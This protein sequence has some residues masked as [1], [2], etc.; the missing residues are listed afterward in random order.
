MRKVDLGYS[1]AEI[2][3]RP[4]LKIASATERDRALDLLRRAEK[5]CLVLRALGTNV[6]FE[7]Q[8]EIVTTEAT[9]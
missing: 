2:I 3:V 8:L 6:K 1:F 9:V 7:P 4:N 5:L